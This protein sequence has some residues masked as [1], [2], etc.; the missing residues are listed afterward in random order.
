LNLP[1]IT[2]LSNGL[3]PACPTCSQ[4]SKSYKKPANFKPKTGKG[5][6]SQWSVCENAACSTSI[7]PY[8]E[9]YYVSP[10]GSAEKTADASDEFVELILALDVSVPVGK[11]RQLWNRGRTFAQQWT[12]PNSKAFYSLVGGCRAFGLSEDQTSVVMLAWLGRHDELPEDLDE[13]QET[14]FSPVWQWANKGKETP[15]MTPAKTIGD[16]VSELGKSMKVESCNFNR[17]TGEWHIQGTVDLRET[18]LLFDIDN[19]D[20]FDDADLPWKS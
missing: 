7:L 16:I 19:D 20:A 18:G 9:T 5:Y 6:Y 13:W 15:H 3:G 14:T 17:N 11:L 4:P 10:E 2:K 8:D 12:M 1:S